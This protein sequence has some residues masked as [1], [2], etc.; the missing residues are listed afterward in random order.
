MEVPGGSHD[1]VK[2]CIVWLPTERFLQLLGV[3]YKFRGLSGAPWTGYERDL[4]AD[5]ILHCSHH[6]TNGFPRPR[7]HIEFIRGTVL[8]QRF[9]R[10]DVSPRQVAHMDVVT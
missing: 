8:K 1:V 6:F 4:A 5:H 10:G 9:D 2:I 3:G 7:P